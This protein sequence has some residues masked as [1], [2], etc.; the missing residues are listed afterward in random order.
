MKKEKMKNQEK[1]KDGKSWM[2][3]ACL[4]FCLSVS[5][6]MPHHEE[7]L[8]MYAHMRQS[9]HASYKMLVLYLPNMRRRRREWLICART[10]SLFAVIIIIIIMV[11]KIVVVVEVF[12]I[13]VAAI[14]HAAWLCR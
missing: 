7:G 8:E 3:R 4:S 6:C 14:A 11:M 13:C 5:L 10:R 12:S 1:E 2:M 9:N